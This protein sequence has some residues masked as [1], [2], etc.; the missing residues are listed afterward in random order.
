MATRSL[1]GVILGEGYT[2][3]VVDQARDRKGYFPQQVMPFAGAV[4]KD[5][6]AIA[7]IKNLRM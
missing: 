1:G 4:G 7:Q 6:V 5:D 3:V 2:H